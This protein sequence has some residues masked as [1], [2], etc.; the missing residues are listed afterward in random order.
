MN[1]NKPTQDFYTGLDVIAL[2][3]VYSYPVSVKNYIFSS[4]L[5]FHPHKNSALCHWKPLLL[6]TPSI[7]KILDSKRHSTRQKLHQ[8]HVTC[9]YSDI[10]HMMVLCGVFTQVHGDENH[11]TS[12]MLFLIILVSIDTGYVDWR[13]SGNSAEKLI[14]NQ[15]SVPEFSDFILFLIKDVNSL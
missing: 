10:N 5:V 7:L 15:C 1:D 2:H 13:A 8:H 3:H 4:V 12:V 9:V 6:K 14:I 11:L